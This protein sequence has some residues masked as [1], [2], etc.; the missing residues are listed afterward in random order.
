MRAETILR[1]ATIA[2]AA[3]TLIHFTIW[4]MIVIIGGHFTDPWWLWISLPPA[5]ALL[6][7]RAAL[8]GR[9]SRR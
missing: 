6:A 3:L 8:S 1:V 2:W 4:S 7:A 5:V 9:G